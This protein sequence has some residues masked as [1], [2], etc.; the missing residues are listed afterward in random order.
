MKHIGHKKVAKKKYKR[1]VAAVAGAAIVSSA[2]LP[3][4]PIAKV[5]AATPSAQQ[6]EAQNA[7]T[8]KPE[9]QKAEVNK[10]QEQ[11]DEVNKPD[12]H[13]EE[14][15]NS[16]L[17]AARQ[18]ADAHGFDSGRDNL[19]L[20]SRSDTEAT[21]LLRT[22]NG[23]TYKMRLVKGSDNVW[24]VT[25]VSRI[26]SNNSDER[27]SDPVRVVRDRAASFGF[28]AV[29]DRFTL[30]SQSGSKATVSVIRS[31][32][33][34]KVDLE[35][36][37]GEWVITTIRGIGN[38]R[39]PATFTPASLFNYRTT[40]TVTNPLTQTILYSTDK[41]ANWFWHEDSYPDDMSFGI[42][43][44][45]PSV[46]GADKLLPSEILDYMK[47]VNFDQSFVLTANL[48]TVADQGFGIGIEKVA[49]VG[50]TITV[51]V[52][53]E[54]PHDGTPRLDN[55][56]K[57]SYISIDRGTIDFTQTIN[58]AFVD[59]HGTLLGSYTIIPR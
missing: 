3:G 49:Q 30:L 53:G 8:T 32:Q 55:S 6:Q 36:R 40:T 35:R 22:D 44:Q 13:Q 34:F 51:T 24:Q 41:Y 39:Y 48:G 58:V 23:K 37:D 4:V 46:N 17:S 50:N 11:K 16:P 43:F 12:R 56:Q 27:R 42:F 9:A 28:D 52:R 26:D 18:Y 33:D 14:A 20:Q 38:G 10:P 47:G 5:Q 29:R 21:V 31:G 15:R 45:H 2:M 19:S 7:G 25:S 57:Y 54:S 1:I 59:Y